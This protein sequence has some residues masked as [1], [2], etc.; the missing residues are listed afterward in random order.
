MAEILPDIKDAKAA[1]AILNRLAGEQ[2]IML[3]EMLR[4]HRP[5]EWK[6]VIE[7]EGHERIAKA[8]ESGQGTIFWISPFVHMDIVAKA[9]LKRC[10]V[11]FVHLMRASHGLSTTEFGGAMLNPVMRRPEEAF[12]MRREVIDPMNAGLAALHLSRVLKSGG[13]VWI[14]AARSMHKRRAKPIRVP[15]LDGTFDFAPGASTLALKMRANLLPIVTLREPRGN[16]RV[17]VGPNL[18]T[19]AIYRN[20]EPTPG[21]IVRKYADFVSGYVADYPQQWRGWFQL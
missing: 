9:A 5:G 3:L 20:G 18:N 4:Y 2:V 12:T 10:G 7:I 8:L 21:L 17:V 11:D 16:Y 1:D 6:P 14:T 19:P 13:S 15:F